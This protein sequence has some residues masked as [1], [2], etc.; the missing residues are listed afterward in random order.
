MDPKITQAISQMNPQI[1]Q[2]QAQ[3][4]SPAVMLSIL[5]EQE[6]FA[7]LAAEQRNGGDYDPIKDSGWYNKKQ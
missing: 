3:G 5:A 7:R 2:A 6:R 1:L 4:L